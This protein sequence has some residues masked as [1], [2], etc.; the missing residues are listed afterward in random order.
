MTDITAQPLPAL[1][2]N[3]VEGSDTDRMISRINELH[4]QGI[5]VVTS[6][7]FPD[8]PAA[9][10][11]SNMR[12]LAFNG[13]LRRVGHGLYDLVTSGPMPTIEM[14][15]AAQERRM[16]AEIHVHDANGNPPRYGSPAGPRRLTILDQVVIIQ[17]CNRRK[18]R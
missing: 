10:I 3:T 8:V 1:T 17:T 9:S 4:Q 5:R 14:C 16:G 15:L 11:R 18:A 2:V 12:R 6:A 13:K 7:D